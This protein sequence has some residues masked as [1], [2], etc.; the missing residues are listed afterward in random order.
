MTFTVRLGGGFSPDSMERLLDQLAGDNPSDGAWTP[1]VDIVENEKAVVLVADLAGV[2]A[3]KTKVAIDGDVVRI[4]G[5]RGA[6]S[7]TSGARYH[8]M[9]IETGAFVRA[10]RISV[11]FDPAG[12]KAQRKDGLL[13]IT[14]PKAGPVETKMIEVE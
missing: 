8:R 4:Y 14:F 11:P 5:E 6:T 3:D 1:A 13:Y 2:A 10:F 12:V 7:P 9:E